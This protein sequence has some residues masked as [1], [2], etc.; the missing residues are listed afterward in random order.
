[1]RIG[2]R[3][4]TEPVLPAVRST[5]PSTSMLTP[6]SSR[7][8][9]TRCHDESAIE[10]RD[11]D[12]EH[13]G[14]ATAPH[15]WARRPRCRPA[16]STARRR[17]RTAPSGRGWSRSSSGRRQPHASR[18][19]RRR[20]SPGIQRRVGRTSTIARGQPVGAAHVGGERDGRRD[21][22]SAPADALDAPAVRG[23]D[24]PDRGAA[25]GVGVGRRAVVVGRRPSS[26]DSHRSASARSGPAP[27]DV[28]G[29]PDARSS[30]AGPDP[31]QPAAAEEQQRPEARRRRTTAPSGGRPGRPPRPLLPGPV[32]QMG[33]ARP[34]IPACLPRTRA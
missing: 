23:H 15:S 30:S 2:Q 26:K 8:Q 6:R 5:A 16:A 4:F 25:R 31:A 19:T 1:M 14:A 12:E 17:C 9:T 33:D 32:P 34:S 10:T 3:L 7:R 13:V 11:V 29:R 28:G 20:G 21:S 27:A 18:R 24:P 22:R